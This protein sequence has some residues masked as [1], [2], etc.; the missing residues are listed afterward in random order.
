MNNE[1]IISALETAIQASLL[2]GTE[3]MNVYVSAEY[4]ILE[5]ED[6]SPVTQADLIASKVIARTLAKTNIPIICEEAEKQPYE[7]RKK[8]T[9]VWLV[10]P[11]D[12]TQN[13]IEQ[14]DDF[15]V[16]IALIEKQKPIAGVIYIPAQ[17]VLYFG[18]P[19]IG[20]YV[21]HQVSVSIDSFKWEDLLDKALKLPLV[22]TK[23]SYTIVASY[24]FLDKE[25]EQYI[26]DQLYSIPNSSVINIGSSIKFLEMASGRADEYPRLMHLHEW[27]IAAGHAIAVASGCTMKQFH[28]SKDVLYNTESLKSPCFILKRN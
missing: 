25:T 12:G 8:Y 10:D 16:N 23:Q 26:A 15:T 18:I 24:S 20:A 14:C 7:K 22:T 4:D 11:L 2:A 17:D 27:D 9:H 19:S 21:I 1:Q 28:D 3:I 6:L 13:F 5:K